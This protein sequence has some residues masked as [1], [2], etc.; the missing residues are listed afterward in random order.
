MNIM[1]AIEETNTC[2]GGLCATNET[3][4]MSIYVFSNVNDGVPTQSCHESLTDLVRSNFS[5]YKLGFIVPLV[6]TCLVVAF[7][8]MIILTKF[9]NLCCK[10]KKKE[11][12]KS[13]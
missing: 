3:D 9:K 4:F 1:A 5:T 11:D 8:M 10:D 6:E 12:K 2:S 7:Y 13:K